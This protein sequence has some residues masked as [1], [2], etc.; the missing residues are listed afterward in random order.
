LFNAARLGARFTVGGELLD[1]E[2]QD[3]ALW[4][5]DLIALGHYYF[6]QSQ[7]LGEI[8][9]YH[10][11]AAIA[12]LH[13]HAKSFADTDWATI[14]QLY[15]KL[16]DGN[17]NPFISL[18]Y[19][20]ALY[21]DGQKGLAFDLL[22]KLRRTFLEKYY[23]LHAALGKLYLLEKDYQKSDYYLNHALSLTSFQEEK[24]FVKKMLLKN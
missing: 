6:K 13:C 8:S 21:Y 18:N 17:P 24:D 22:E 20:I 3:R 2:E 11:E 9:S 7:N 5:S 19:A 14:T 15:T 1:L 4:D 10:Y 23:L 16:L 12:F